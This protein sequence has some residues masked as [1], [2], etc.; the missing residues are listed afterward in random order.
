MLKWLIRRKLNAF[1]RQH[2][3]DTSYMREVLDTDLGALLLFHRATGLGQYRK[4]VPLDVYFAA[5]LTASLDADCGPCT[6]LCVGFALHAGVEPRQIAA[7]VA[8]DEARMSPEVALGARFAR[9]VI[10]RSADA[11][12]AREEIVRRWG[13]RAV[14]ALAFSIMNA[15]MYPTLKYALGHGKACTRVVVAGEAV[16]PRRLAPAPAPAE[17]SAF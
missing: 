17:H 7:I 15:Q 6:Q 8:S 9:A 1:E 5:Q 4:S 2:G 12:A 14:L 10:A 3:Y 11:D 16:V 13:P